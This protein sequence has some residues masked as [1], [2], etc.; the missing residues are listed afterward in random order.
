MAL[1]IAVGSTVGVPLAVV[2]G[3]KVVVATGL[4]LLGGAFVWISG[5]DV[6]T[7]YGAIAGQMVLLGVGMGFTTAPATE[8]LMGA[9][10]L[11]RAGVGSAI[12]DTTRELGSTLGVA[13]MGSVFASLFTGASRDRRRGSSRLGSYIR[14]TPPWVPASP[15]PGCSPLMAPPSRQ[16]RSTR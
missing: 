9:V 1:S 10:G 6:T 4:A 13:V 7:T 5:N 8:S 12:N 3:T 15:P 11:D 16:R 14:R 2:R